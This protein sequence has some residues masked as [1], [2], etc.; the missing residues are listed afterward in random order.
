MPKGDA[1]TAIGINASR[2][3]R[4]PSFFFDYELDKDGHLNRM[5]WCDSQS[6]QDY[7]D[8]GDVVVFY[9]TYKMNRYGM[10]FVPFV[11]LNNHRKTT[12]FGCDI[13]SDETEETYKWLL[14]TFL[15]AMCQKMPKSVI[16]D[17]DA[18]MIRAIREVLLD[19]WH[20]ICTFHIEKIYEDSPQ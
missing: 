12:I 20:R 11:G 13:V 3:E 7:E 18:A 8:F 17:A 10:P 1:A 2:K 16:T 19:V 5:F 15:R 6:R 14:R 4:D 9:S